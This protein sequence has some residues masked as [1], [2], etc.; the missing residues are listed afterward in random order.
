M[1]KLSI[2][3][4]YAFYYLVVMFWADIG[5][6]ANTGYFKIQ[7][8]DVG[9]GD[10]MLITTPNKKKILVDGGPSSEID[11][12]LFYEMPF[13]C[14]LDYVVL[15]HAHYDHL[16]GL[17]RVVQRC[18]VDTILFNDA[19]YESRAYA[20]W[21]SNITQNATQKVHSAIISDDFF[22]DGV[23]FYVLWP[24]QEFLD[25]FKGNINNRSIVLFVDY[26]EF[27]ALLLGDAQI[28]VLPKLDISRVQK[29]IDGQLDVYK[30]SH[31][32]AKNGLYLQ[33]FKLINPKY[34]VISVGAQNKYGH[35]HKEVLDF[36]ESLETT[37]Y[38]TDING[39]VEF[40]AL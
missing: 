26:N 3:I 22:I 11:R 30:A 37:V 17:N 5:F 6:R 8:F 32:G 40:H 10:A 13:Y 21:T 4:I 27:E 16:A 34:V 29:Y 15:T 14:H 28:E 23:S 19:A 25:S 33:L 36:F 20:T 2:L 1:E 9:Q 31:H 24:T 7:F 35:P 18:T 38:R 39:T 12:Y